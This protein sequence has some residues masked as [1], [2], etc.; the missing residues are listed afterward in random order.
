VPWLTATSSATSQAPSRSAPGQSIRP[1]ARTGDSGT[2]TAMPI[3]AAT[4]PTSGNQ[5][6]QWYE[7]CSVIGPASTI[8]TRRRCP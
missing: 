3:V 2:A 8:P 5:N 7:K 1:G 4:I 6:S